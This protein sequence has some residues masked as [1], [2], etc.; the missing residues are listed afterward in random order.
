[1]AKIKGTKRKNNCQKT[2]HRSN[3]C[4]TRTPL[5]LRVNLGA[6]NGCQVPFPLVSLVV[7]F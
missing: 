5:N 4:E 1:M 7:L 6:P 2:P 3:D